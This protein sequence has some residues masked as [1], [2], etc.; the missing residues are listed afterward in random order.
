[1]RPQTA[2]ML[3]LILVAVG[4]CRQIGQA[5]KI[6]DDGGNAVLEISVL[7]AAHVYLDGIY[8]GESPLVLERLPIGS[9]ELRLERP[10]YLTQEMAV[11]VMRGKTSIVTTTMERVDPPSLDQFPDM[12]L[13]NG[14][15]DGLV[16]VGQY[17]SA[18]ETLAAQQLIASFADLDENVILR[19]TQ[20][21][22]PTGK[23]MI[24]IGRPVRAAGG[25]SI[26][27]LFGSTIEDYPEGT[28][29][30]LV[31]WV[32]DGYALII[33]GG[34]D[35]DV[36]AMTRYLAAWAQHPD[37]LQGRRIVLLTSSLQ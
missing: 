7:P 6:R 32:G 33:T 37:D 30:I 21:T 4:G 12:F 25:N 9:H 23:N 18:E 20:V 15:I 8:R 3:L 29:A 10:G 35:D 16:I 24:L 11:S 5:Y 34:S 22:L 2:I 31:E 27:D 26:L 14:R 17:S 13:H 36:A 1:M 19:D 28:G